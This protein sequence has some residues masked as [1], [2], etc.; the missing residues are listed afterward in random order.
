VTYQFCVLDP[1]GDYYEF[2][3]AIALRGGDT[4]ALVED[5]LRVLDR[6]V[7]NTIVNV[8]DRRLDE[9]PEVLR[10]LL[11]NRSRLSADLQT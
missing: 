6:P 7:E 5:A 9:R 10:A 11:V 1:E 8:M 3:G 4:R 2:P